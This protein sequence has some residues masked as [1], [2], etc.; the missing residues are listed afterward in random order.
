MSAAQAPLLVTRLHRDVRVRQPA[1]MVR[2]VQQGVHDVSGQFRGH[3]V[4]EG[5]GVAD[6]VPEAIEVREL[7]SA[8]IPEGVF[9]VHAQVGQGAE[10]VIQRGVQQHLLV[11][12]SAL[13]TDARKPGRHSC[14]CRARTCSKLASPTSSITAERAL[15]TETKDMPTSRSST[16]TSSANR[17]RA[18]Q[19]S[20]EAP[21]SPARPGLLSWRGGLPRTAGG[22]EG[23]NTPSRAWMFPS[24]RVYRPGQTGRGALRPG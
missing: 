9:L 22:C 5:I 18:R 16:L 4:P 21:S 3:Q 23:R 6:A 7:P 13:D 19:P 15:A 24:L 8:G 20:P 2:R 10:Q 1:E 12:L 11:L 17:S 14:S